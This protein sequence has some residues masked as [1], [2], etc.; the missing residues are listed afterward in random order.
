MNPE[1]LSRARKLC[2]K[3]VLPLWVTIKTV[4]TKLNSIVFKRFRTQQI[5]LNRKALNIF[6]NNF[7]TF[8]LPSIL[9]IPEEN[10]LAREHPWPGHWIL[11]FLFVAL[12]VANLKLC[13]RHS[14]LQ[15]ALSKFNPWEN[16]LHFLFWYN[17]NFFWQN[18]SFFYKWIESSFLSSS[19][20]AGS[21]SSSVSDSG[22]DLKMIIW[23]SS[24][25]Y[26]GGIVFGK[27]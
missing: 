11:I 2:L 19:Y 3:I 6:C 21:L 16:V 15:E 9:M 20:A 25:F 22:G 17:L 1:T 7:F 4:K 14:S 5:L 10:V 27:N 23:A 18:P 24:L 12:F 8:S 26:R 13:S